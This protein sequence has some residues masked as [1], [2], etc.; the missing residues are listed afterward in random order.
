MRSVYII[1][2]TLIGISACFL[3]YYHIYQ[4][5]RRR[6]QCIQQH[7]RT[8]RERVTTEK[9][10]RTTYLEN[11][12]NATRSRISSIIH[13]TSSPLESRLVNLAYIL[14]RGVY[15]VLRPDPDIATQCCRAVIVHTDAVD[16]HRRARILLYS[17][18]IPDADVSDISKSLDDDLVREID[19]MIDTLAV[20]GYVS[21]PKSAKNR[22]EL[23]ADISTVYEPVDDDTQNSH[24]SGVVTSVKHI[25]SNLPKHTIQR[26][27]VE[28][29]IGSCSLDDDTKAK[30]LYTLD[31]LSDEDVGTGI[32]EMDA[33]SRVWGSGTDKNTIILQLASAIEHGVPVCHSGKLARIASAMD[34]G[35]TEHSIVPTWVLRR[36]ASDIAAKVRRD[37]LERASSREREQYETDGHDALQ[38]QMIDTFTRDMK[39][40]LQKAPE[41]IQRLIL[42]EYSGAF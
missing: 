25:L 34:T 40:H 1:I 7:I 35:E 17:M 3:V 27:D 18:H 29:Y 2:G 14:S 12:Y 15:P 4:R 30:A 20:R 42:E 5:E 24:D 16:E 9:E 21:R 39:P 8:I 19:V 10:Q 23:T 13:D 28:E 41:H 11:L 31:T 38:T 36:H 33:L 6:R 22:A 37:V 26:A 32:A